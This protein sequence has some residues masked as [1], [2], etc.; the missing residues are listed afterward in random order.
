MS[1]ND[2]IMIAMNNGKV[3]YLDVKKLVP[4]DR[5]TLARQ[6]AQCGLVYSAT[7]ETLSELKGVY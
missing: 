6:I 5:V 1:K 2:T 3:L 4:E 7:V